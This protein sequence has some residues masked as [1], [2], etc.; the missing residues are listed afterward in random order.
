MASHFKNISQ[1]RNDS[2]S[3]KYT[4]AFWQKNKNCQFFI[5]DS[6][7]VLFFKDNKGEAFFGPD[8][9]DSF[10]VEFPASPNKWDFQGNTDFNKSMVN[11]GFMTRIRNEVFF[12]KVDA[13]KEKIWDPLKLS[14]ELRHHA[15]FDYF[16]QDMLPCVNPRYV[17][18]KISYGEF[19][20]QYIIWDLEENNE[21]ISTYSHSCGDLLQFAK[22]HDFIFAKSRNW[23]LDIFQQNQHCLYLNSEDMHDLKFKE[24]FVTYRQGYK[25]NHNISKI[26]VDRGLENSHSLKSLFSIKLADKAL[27][28]DDNEIELSQFYN[29]YARICFAS[30]KGKTLFSTL[31]SNPVQLQKL[32]DHLENKFLPGLLQIV[33]EDSHGKTAIDYALDYGYLDSLDIMMTALQKCSIYSSSESILKRFSDLVNTQLPSF[34]AYLD[35]AWFVTNKQLQSVEIYDLKDK[36]SMVTVPSTT[37]FL[38]PDMIKQHMVK[39]QKESKSYYRNPVEHYRIF[40][41]CILLLSKLNGFL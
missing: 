38:S 23:I 28:L 8:K 24:S 37:T 33:N 18:L 15:D 36:S 16:F 21:V 39:P 35:K 13:E 10:E 6:R 19:A 12:R 32:W 11:G 25:F 20:C 5:T 9:S 22:S 7:V 27:K 26:L 30:H 2:F 31:V 41:L 34:Y 14:F 4:N 3:S 40:Q 1:L 17:V 29:Y